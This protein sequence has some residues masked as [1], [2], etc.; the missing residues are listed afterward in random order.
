MK[1]E[2]HPTI[3][4]PTIPA[5][6]VPRQ[7]LYFLMLFLGIIS[8][9]W[10]HGHPVY[11][12]TILSLTVLCS[13]VCW[14]PPQWFS[15]RLRMLLMT[16]FVTGAVSWG[17]VR[18]L[19]HVPLDKILI[20]CICAL[21]LSF[22]FSP[23]RQDY[24]YML[25][26][27]GLLILYGALLP[28]GIYLLIV[29]AAFLL[30]IL[31][32]CGSRTIGLS[33]DPDLKPGAAFT[34]C[35]GKIVFQILLVLGLL[36][37]FY[38]CFPTEGTVRH[39]LFFTSFKTQN[40]NLLPPNVNTWFRPQQ[41]K[42]SDVGAVFAGKPHRPKASDPSGAPVQTKTSSGMKSSGNGSSPPGRDLV[43]VA[44]APAKLYWLGQ[45]YDRYD[46]QEW[47]CSEALSRQRTV[48]PQDNS[49]SLVQQDITIEKWISPVLYSAYRADFCNV[50][51][52]NMENLEGNF[53]QYRFRDVNRLPALPFTYSINSE[54]PYLNNLKPNPNFWP[55]RIRRE[56][57]LSLPE[58]LISP[59]LRTRTAAIVAKA[60]TD[61]DKAIAIRDWLRNSFSYKQ[62]STP[63][64]PGRESVDFFVFDLKEG[65]CEYFAAAM[66]VMARLAHLPARVAIGFSPGNYNVLTKTFEVY[67][68]H[69][70]AW[71]QLYIKGKGW[72]TFD[73]TPPGAVESRATPFLIGALRDPFGNEWRVR[74]PELAAKMQEHLAGDGMK[75]EDSVLD[76]IIY[77]AVM[78]PENI[79]RAGS[80]LQEK[81]SRESVLYKKLKKIG[82]DFWKDCL[83]AFQHLKTK[84]VKF[85][86]WSKQHWQLVLVLL[87][88][89]AALAFLVL[90]LLLIG[91]RAYIRLHCRQLLRTAQES[92]AGNPDAAVKM[93]Y[94]AVRKILH[95][96]GMPRRRN[97]DLF[98]YAAQIRA[99]DPRCG[100]AAWTVF[101]LYSRIEYG[102]RDASVH[103]AKVALKA[104]LLLEAGILRHSRTLLNPTDK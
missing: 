92:T 20:E 46:G 93:S 22:S 72:L 103:E 10:L 70:H 41:S 60:K 7:P 55:E 63:T 89:L 54:V 97:I 34:Y 19:Q 16:L 104:A 2:N 45:L 71:S 47:H 18:G 42:P 61:Y 44:R 29:P 48:P 36:P 4:L 26:I 14:L 39:G 101:V 56:T 95:L 12:V 77:E 62:M 96:A 87:V 35:W 79:S 82:N 1:P 24:G 83:R 90:R 76:Q 52:K 88:T 65:H 64:P 6:R 49:H 21:A 31:I 13:T 85:W 15:L 5:T 69:G 68:Y 37:L 99:C 84:T 81:S 59:R 17:V 23:R 50:D 30:T 67:E 28:R 57:Y 11:T 51:T 98:D 86:S 66:T 32:L 80:K 58:K 91:R 33:G 74:P 3:D 73:A 102:G 75:E 53:Y 40:D 43:F 25:L 38:L 78:L 100:R 94:R 27:S 9:L 8:A